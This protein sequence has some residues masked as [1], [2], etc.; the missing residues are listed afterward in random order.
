M[1]SSARREEAAKSGVYKTGDKVEVLSSEEG[2]SDAWAT[3][4][5]VSQQKNGWLVEYSKFV[6]GNGQLLREKARQPPPPP[7]SACLALPAA[8]APRRP[9]G[10]GAAA[11]WRVSSPH[12]APRVRDFGRGPVTWAVGGGPARSAASRAAP[13]AR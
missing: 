12:E 4:T 13:R 8:L 3:A 9:G 10:N 1:S 6:D 11:G 5:V 2:F 7:P